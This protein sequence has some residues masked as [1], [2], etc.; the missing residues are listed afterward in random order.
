[1]FESVYYDH[2]EGNYISDYHP[3]KG[4]TLQVLYYVND[5]TGVIVPGTAVKH[6]PFSQGLF[7]FGHK[8]ANETIKIAV[9]NN[10]EYADLIRI[11]KR[12]AKEI[13]AKGVSLY[14]SNDSKKD[15]LKMYHHGLHR[16]SSNSKDAVA[17]IS[18][19]TF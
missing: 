10:G 6:K 16:Y 5:E 2:Q 8:S 11:W 4:Q 9:D 12:P 3:R 13:I 14:N 7:Q 17:L 18:E 1:M 15:F 19:D